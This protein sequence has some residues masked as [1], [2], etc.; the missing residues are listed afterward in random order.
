VSLITDTRLRFE[1]A[2]VISDET[3]VQVAVQVDDVAR[4]QLERRHEL[5]LCNEQIRRHRGVLSPVPAG[6]AS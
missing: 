1:L 4:V 6:R 5:G 3:Q 2:A